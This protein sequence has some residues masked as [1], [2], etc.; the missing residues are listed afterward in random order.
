MASTYLSPGVYVEERDLGTKP[1]EAV[2][3]TFDPERHEAVS[4]EESD[5]APNRVISEVEKGYF[6]HERLLRP[7]KVIVSKAKPEEEKERL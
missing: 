6:Y 5:Q 4:Q 1:I 7:A 2:G 3:E